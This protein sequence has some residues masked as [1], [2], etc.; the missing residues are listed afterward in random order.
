MYWNPTF[1]KNPNPSII[2][3]IMKS[4]VQYSIEV[5]HLPAHV[6]P[7]FMGNPLSWHPG[8]TDIFGAYFLLQGNALEHWVIGVILLSLKMFSL[9][10]SVYTLPSIL[11]PWNP[12]ALLIVEMLA[13]TTFSSQK[14]FPGTLPCRTL[15]DVSEAVSEYMDASLHKKGWCLHPSTGR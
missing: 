2:L 4:E 1:K 15:L 5:V 11:L 7:Q 12:W 6:H 9:D 8:W 14:S 3:D 10:F 13:K